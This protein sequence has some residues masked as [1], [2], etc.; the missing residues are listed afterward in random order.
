MSKHA[1]LPLL[2]AVLFAVTPAAAQD[3][4]VAAASDLQVA[5]PVLAQRF[6]RATGYRVQPIFGSSGNIAAQIQNGAPYDVFLSADV[7][8]ARRLVELRLAAPDALTAYARG[9]L[10]LWTRKE[11]TLDLRQGLKGLGGPSVRRIAIANPEHAPYGRAAVAALRHEGIYDR[12]R[13]RLILGENISQAAQFAQSGNV[14]AGIIA[15]SLALGPALKAAGR[16]VEI[17]ASAHPP[18]EQAAVW[19]LRAR[20]PAAARRFLQFLREPSSVEYLRT[21]G[22]EAAGR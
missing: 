1:A 10:V 9:R 8:Y 17:P 18:I 6:E 3:V 5:L 20:R 4:T 16:Y 7:V 13:G 15:L 2:I 19:L 14:D 21:M 22:F 11:S 12:V